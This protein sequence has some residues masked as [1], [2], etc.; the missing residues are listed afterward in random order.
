MK[1]L[2][3]VANSLMKTAEKHIH[4][5]A[6]IVA[7]DGVYIGAATTLSV[8]I[9]A[10]EKGPNEGLQAMSGLEQEVIEHMAFKEEIIEKQQ[11]KKQECQS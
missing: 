5:E 11:R 6:A 9:E 4:P 3:K 8:I 2:E 10:M 7:Q 1:V